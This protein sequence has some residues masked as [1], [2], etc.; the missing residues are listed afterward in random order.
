MKDAD[1]VTT[2]AS[3]SA[4]ATGAFLAVA[5]YFRRKR[6]KLSDRPPAPPNR[7]KQD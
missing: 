2:I 1:W 6:E 3:L 4:A 7:R 5:E